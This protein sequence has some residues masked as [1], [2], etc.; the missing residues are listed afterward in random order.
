M[1]IKLETFVDL[2]RFIALAEKAEYD[3]TLIQNS[4]CV[5]GKSIMGIMALDLTNVIMLNCNY[6]DAELFK[7][8]MVKE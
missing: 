6:I 2:K 8:F 7:E 1:P 5:N 4:Y 3:V